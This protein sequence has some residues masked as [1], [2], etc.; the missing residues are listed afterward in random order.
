MAIWIFGVDNSAEYKIQEMVK[1]K[2]EQGK[3]I[4]AN[5]K[6]GKYGFVFGNYKV[7][8]EKMDVLKNSDD[9]GIQSVYEVIKDDEV[10]G[11]YEYNVSILADLFVLDGDILI[12]HEFDRTL[13]KSYVLELSKVLKL[14]ESLWEDIFITVLNRD[15]IKYF[16]ECGVR[17]GNRS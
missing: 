11:L 14:L 5:A 6:Q 7:D 10:L 17:V 8:K 3:K 16:L 15:Y 9:K 2:K 4:V 12:L 13:N 1:R